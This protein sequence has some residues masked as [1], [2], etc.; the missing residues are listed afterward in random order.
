MLRFFKFEAYK[1]RSGPRPAGAAVAGAPAPQ[2]H[3][4]AR[5]RHRYLMSRLSL[6]VLTL[7]PVRS[8]IVDGAAI[9]IMVVK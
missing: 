6:E 5:P 4:S 3:T 2:A 8:C 7:L 1:I 9:Y